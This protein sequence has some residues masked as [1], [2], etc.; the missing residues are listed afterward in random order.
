[1]AARCCYLVN[2]TRW[3]TR[4]SY[5]GGSSVVVFATTLNVVGGGGGGVG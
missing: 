2:V 5:S 1:M 3:L 4:C